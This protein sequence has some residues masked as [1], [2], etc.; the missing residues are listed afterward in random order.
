MA[1]TAPHARNFIR[2]PLDMPIEVLPGSGQQESGEM[3]NLSLGGVAFQCPNAH[4]PGTDVTL[5]IACCN[6]VAEVSGQVAWC[7]P[8]G[9]LFDVGVAFYN[10]GDAYK[11]RMVEQACHIQQYRLDRV[12]EDGCYLSLDEAAREW[13]VRY[14][15]RFTETLP[16]ADTQ[17]TD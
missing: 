16:P 5:R 10:P 3:I 2:H 14:A 6:P 1:T 9:R 12:I 7:E 8:E 4:A 17:D 15:R 11:M 13:I